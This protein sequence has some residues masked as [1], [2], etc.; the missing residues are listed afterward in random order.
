MTRASAAVEDGEVRRFLLA[1]TIGSAL[2]VAL[3]QTALGAFPG[4]NGRIAFVRSGDIWTIKPNGTGL[5]RLTHGPGNDWSPAWSATGRWLAFTRYE[6]E[7]GRYVLFRIRADG[8]VLRRVAE[9]ELLELS[10]PT[11][12]PDGRRIAF[13]EGRDIWVVN[14]NGSGRR[15]LTGELREACEGDDGPD[16]Y[17][18]PAVWGPYGR[19]IAFSW[20]YEADDGSTLAMVNASDGSGYRELDFNGGL[21]DW[22][23]TA[24]D[25]RSS[26]TTS[27][28]TKSCSVSSGTRGKVEST[29]STIPRRGPRGSLGRPTE[30][31][32]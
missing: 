18:G 27:R 12:S 22:G 21:L 17:Y 19:R 24:A 31:G 16:C 23:P 5:Q 14:R 20:T 30:G 4:K 3:P 10:D 1:V 9:S 6:D 29:T 7:E 15:S 32:W 8:K 2:L 11:W 26:T 28:P 25:S 13:T